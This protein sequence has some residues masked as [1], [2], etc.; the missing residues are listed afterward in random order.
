MLPPPPGARLAALGTAG[1]VLGLGQAQGQDIRV[2]KA[3]TMK[4]QADLA[5]LESG[6]E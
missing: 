3:G 1:S 5:I 2:W 4:A 6:A